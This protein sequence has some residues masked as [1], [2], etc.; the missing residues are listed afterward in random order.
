M[1][2]HD[3]SPDLL[4]ELPELYAL[5]LRLQR[6]GVPPA[7]LAERLDLPAEALP[8]ALRLAEA[9]LAA[10]TARRSPPGPR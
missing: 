7:E 9:K 4:D 3:E 10:L 1:T 5:A 2:E 6:A 8:A